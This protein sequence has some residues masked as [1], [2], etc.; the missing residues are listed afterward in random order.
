VCESTIATD[1][2]KAGQRLTVHGWAYSLKDG[3]LKDILKHPI[4]SESQV[5]EL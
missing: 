4:T 1:A 3:L 2:W 5:S